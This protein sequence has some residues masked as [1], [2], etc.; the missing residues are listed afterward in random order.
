MPWKNATPGASSDKHSNVMFGAF[1]LA[2]FFFFWGWE[3]SI[4]GI[5]NV[6]DT[7]KLARLAFALKWVNRFDTVHGSKIGR[8]PVELGSFIILQDC[9][10]PRWLARSLNHQQ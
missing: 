3:K 9:I 10:H 6:G 5:A 4:M 8:S 2:E 7:L 1:N